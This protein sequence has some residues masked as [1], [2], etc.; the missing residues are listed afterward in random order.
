MDDAKESAA[1]VEE[2]RELREILPFTVPV[3]TGGRQNFANRMNRKTSSHFHVPLTTDLRILNRL[4]KSGH[5]R[6]YPAAGKGC[7]ALSK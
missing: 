7:C 5:V 2:T 6:V 1:N 3:S 4:Q